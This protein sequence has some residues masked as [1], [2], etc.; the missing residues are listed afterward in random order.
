V[1][2]VTKAK[3]LQTLPNADWWARI[4]AFIAIVV[5]GLGFLLTYESGLPSIAARAEFLQPIVAGENFNFKI[6]VENNGNTTA[7]HIKPD[8]MIAFASAN[9]DFKP[10]GPGLYANAQ[11][12]EWKSTVSDLGPKGHT[13]I[14]STTPVNFAND[15]ILR[16]V[17]A[18]KYNFYVYGKIPYDDV[19]H[20]SHE[21]HFCF[22]YTQIPG[23]DPLKLSMCSSYNESYN[24]TQ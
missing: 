6:D 9:V 24:E 20:L 19:L 14:F 10:F 21:F 8:F 7:K 5:S 11:R 22:F 12:P 1:G 18:G 3:E 13:V 15:E 23:A 16:E 2:S 17:I 4:P